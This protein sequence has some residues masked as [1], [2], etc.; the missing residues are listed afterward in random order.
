MKRNSQMRFKRK[1]TYIHLYVLIV[2]ENK[3]DKNKF[4]GI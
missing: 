3:P 1:Y 2:L 4:M